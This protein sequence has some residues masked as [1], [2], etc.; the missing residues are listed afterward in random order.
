[1]TSKAKTVQIN[2]GL[3]NVSSAN[4]ITHKSY[5]GNRMRSI[6]LETVTYDACGRLTGASSGTTVIR[7]YSGNCIFEGS[8]LKKV[9]FEGGYAQ[10]SGSTPSYMFFLTDHLGSVRVVAEADGRH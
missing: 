5:T 1:M 3:G 9:L 2:N 10:M 4:M 6:P 8:V 7:N